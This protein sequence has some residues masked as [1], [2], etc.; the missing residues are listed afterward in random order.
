[1]SRTRFGLRLV[2]Y[3][4]IG[5][6]AVVGVGVVVAKG[7]GQ[8]PDEPVILKQGTSRA[9][10]NWE[11]R[12]SRSEQGDCIALSV[13]GADG[14]IACGFD[15]PNTTEVGVNGNLKP[16]EGDFYLYGL[17]STRVAWIVAEGLDHK[18]EV[19]TEPMPSVAHR[20]E[21]HFFI[22]V[23]EPVENVVALVALDEDREVIQRLEFPP[24]RK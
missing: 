21:L 1:M 15:I 16:G 14:N 24:P 18:T 23:R 6:L 8:L 2:G 12:L 19:R 10:A 17:T 22:L 7:M 5:I 11:F 9:G 3:V 4:A 20:P 13:D